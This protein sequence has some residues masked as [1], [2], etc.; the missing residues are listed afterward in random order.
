MRNG[1][2][3]FE[4]TDFN[5]LGNHVDTSVE[6]PVSIDSEPF[7][8]EI[9]KQNSFLV[10]KDKYH[11]LPLCA[12]FAERPNPLGNMLTVTL[13]QIDKFPLTMDPDRGF[14][15]QSEE[16]DDRSNLTRGKVEQRLKNS[17][18]RPPN[19][20]AKATKDGRGGVAIAREDIFNIAGICTVRLT[21]MDN[22]RRPFNGDEEEFLL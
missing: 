4:V 20:M 8:H 19:S 6:R 22:R 2:L 12:T 5:S 13:P 16:L 9:Y 10:S 1:N 11:N 17:L 15:M 3:N 18:A 21:Y 14:A 7:G